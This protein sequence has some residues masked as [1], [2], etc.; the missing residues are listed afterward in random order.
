M[1]KLSSSLEGK[2]DEAAPRWIEPK[3]CHYFIN[4]HFKLVPCVSIKVLA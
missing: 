4:R 2:A 1:K 3:V